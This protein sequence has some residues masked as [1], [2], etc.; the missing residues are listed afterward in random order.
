MVARCLLVI[1]KRE[2]LTEFQPEIII[3]NGGS[4]PHFAD[5]LG[6]LGLTIDAFF[7]LSTLVVNTAEEVCQGQVVFLIGSGYNPTVLPLCWYALAAGV[8]G[9]DEITVTDP[10]APPIIPPWCHQQAETTVKALK[11]ILKKY[12][13]CFRWSPLITFL[14][15]ST[16]IQ[17]RETLRK[18][19]WQMSQIS[20][21]A[22]QLLD[23]KLS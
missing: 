19:N 2:R 21:K 9:L 17:P 15:T 7:R 22:F 23:A 8:V 4:D 13:R 14:L 20:E 5:I 18:W 6:G 16:Y 10:T 1:F 3:A 11:Q 12:W